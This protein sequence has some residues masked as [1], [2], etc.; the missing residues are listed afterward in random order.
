MWTARV[1]SPAE[2]KPEASDEDIYSKA[3]AAATVALQGLVPVAA[4]ATPPPTSSSRDSPES[5]STPSPSSPRPPPPTSSSHD[6]PESPS[7]PRESP[8]SPSSTVVSALAAGGS[9][10]DSTHADVAGAKTAVDGGDGSVLKTQ[11]PPPPPRVFKG[12][13]PLYPSLD[14]YGC[15][16]SQFG[17]WAVNGIGEWG[18]PRTAAVGHGTGGGHAADGAATIAAGPHS[19]TEDYMLLPDDLMLSAVLVLGLMD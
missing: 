6:S 16:I 10:G 18:G 2:L 19:V 8:R 1:G 9:G 15:I 7:T 14:G 3:R 11:S 13:L 5:P 4:A 12:P 17:C